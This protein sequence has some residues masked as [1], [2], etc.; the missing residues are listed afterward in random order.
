MHRGD[1][2]I[3]DGLVL[4][5]AAHVTDACLVLDATDHMELTDWQKGG[6][7]QITKTILRVEV[8]NQRKLNPGTLKLWDNVNLF[9]A[10]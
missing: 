1:T 3:F 4:I 2:S 5:N 6:S 7:V 8:G 10:H 9:L